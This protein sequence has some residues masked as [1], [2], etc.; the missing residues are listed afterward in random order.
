MVRDCSFLSGLVYLVNW[1]QCGELQ[2]NEIAVSDAHRHLLLF[3]PCGVGESG[4]IQLK[5]MPWC[6]FT[7]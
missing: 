5:E 4:Q 3:D 2:L 6:F 1:G 7:Y